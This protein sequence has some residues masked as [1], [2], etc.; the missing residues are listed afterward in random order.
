[1]PIYF[2]TLKLSKVLHKQ[3]NLV[4]VLQ[5]C[6]ALLMLTLLIPCT[7]MFF[8][9]LKMSIFHHTEVFGLS[10]LSHTLSCICAL[11]CCFRCLNVLLFTLSL[12]NAYLLCNSVQMIFL[13]LSISRL[14]QI[15]SVLG[16]NFCF[17]HSIRIIK[18][19]SYIS[20]LTVNSGK[21]VFNFFFI[22]STKHSGL[23]LK[24]CFRPTEKWDDCKLYWNE[25][26]Q[27]EVDTT[28]MTFFF[29]A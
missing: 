24:F 17:K 20:N 19:S 6:S 3:E 16:V 25:F 23:H 28:H 12:H 8:T 26:S 5:V 11:R 9:S 7:A 10:L 15:R 14:T 2:D 21:T 29:N 22:P 18:F 27:A 4:H 1:M 13:L